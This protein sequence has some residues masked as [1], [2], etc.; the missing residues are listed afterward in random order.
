MERVKAAAKKSE[1][2]F[3]AKSR[4]LHK[5]WGKGIVEGS[6]GDKIT[7]LFDEVGRKTLALEVVGKEHLL[8]PV[9]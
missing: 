6:E 1:G 4:V 8:E 7:I 5:E 9:S 3:A 2:P